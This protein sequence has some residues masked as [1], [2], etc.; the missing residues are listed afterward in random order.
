MLNLRA[1][2]GVLALVVASGGFVAGCGGDSSPPAAEAPP[3]APVVA[4]APPP[5]PVEAPAP[6]PKPEPPPP[7]PKRPDDVAAWQPDD[8][9]SAR[10][11]R[12][13]KLAAAVESLGT[14]SSGKADVLPLLVELLEPEKPPAPAEGAP[15][16]ANRFGSGQRPPEANVV[17]A[18]IGAVG[19]NGTPEGAEVLA[20]LLRGELDPGIPGRNVSESVLTA[21]VTNPT[22]AHAEMLLTAAFT[23]EQYRPPA[24]EQPGDKM[25][26]SRGNS[27]SV[28]PGQLKQDATA[29]L[30]AGATPPVRMMLAARIAASTEGEDVQ[31]F[32]QML[33]EPRLE[34]L[35]AQ[36]VLLSQPRL[37]P[38][39]RQQLALMM[40]QLAMATIDTWLGIPANAPISAPTG[41]T[42]G[43]WL[44]LTPSKGSMNVF[45]SGNG[46]GFRAPPAQIPPNY[47]ANL[48]DG[49][50]GSGRMASSGGSRAQRGVRPETVAALAALFWNPAFGQMVVQQAG[51]VDTISKALPASVLAAAL[52][53]AET[54]ATL[55][56]TNRGLWDEGTRDLKLGGLFGEAFHDPGLMLVVK[57]VPRKEDPERVEARSARADP[58]RIN[59]SR[60]V[61]RPQDKSKDKVREKERHLY[62]WMQ[63]SEEMVYV[64]TSRFRAAAV[65]ALPASA[66]S[67]LP[68]D[69]AEPAASTP[70]AASR[71]RSAL[72]AGPDQPDDDAFGTREA[73]TATPPAEQLPVELH[74]GANVV[75]EYHL[76]WP[77]DLEG[78]IPG[79]QVSPLIIHYVRIEESNRGGKLLT[80]YQKFLKGAK[81]RTIDRGRWIDHVDGGTAPGH[82][83]SI[84][85]LIANVNPPTPPPSTQPRGRDS[86]PKVTDEP[87]VV[88]ILSI[89][90]VDPYPPEAED[91]KTETRPAA[92][93]PARAAK[94]ADDDSETPGP[95]KPAAKKPAAKRP[96]AQ[97]PATESAPEN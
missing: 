85:V 19:K 87:L 68:A 7:P 13:Q 77:A 6:P 2:L 51:S 65:A 24:A 48:N 34:N 10:V 97:P 59:G 82:K 60:L 15:P 30:K 92:K 26:L 96:A 37:D 38:Q 20:R 56:Q 45:G 91:E 63:A 47:D 55:A 17:A 49:G 28:S 27:N 75:A 84:D 3:P 93:K 53:L 81:L 76:N 16:A 22:P 80:H 94:A 78:K 62:E 9:R 72:P 52:P 83:R 33:L 25:T 14:R 57:G 11:E 23:P 61:S 67:P 44:D 31:P 79:V 18:L 58:R 41:Y 35:P 86:K 74:E 73:E 42:P 54:R 12:D 66:A 70:A 46:A 5:A 21:L 40:T 29:K 32:V 50:G 90:A 95:K 8:F 39:T 43:N 4:Q 88:E 69:K 64:W 71:T 89:E 1:K 36:V